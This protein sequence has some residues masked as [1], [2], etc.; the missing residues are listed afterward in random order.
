MT[1]LNLPL[2]YLRWHYS[3]AWV[4]LLRL[5][6]NLAWFLYHFFSIDL[7]LPT[8]FSPWKRLHESRHGAAGLLG[9][10]ILNF[11]LLCFG[12]A[13]RLATLC[14]GIASLALLALFFVAF[15]FLWVLMPAIPFL[16]MVQGL[17]GLIGW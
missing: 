3:A 17:I 4:D 2:A 14:L 13:L 12:F 6:M 7:L 11:I 1:L 16:L 8:L 15:L 5:F 9:A 10:L